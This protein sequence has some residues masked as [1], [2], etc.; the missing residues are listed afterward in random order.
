MKP[1]IEHFQDELEA[2]LDKFSSEGLTLGEV[3]GTLEIVKHNW[4]FDSREEN[5][6]ETGLGSI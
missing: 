3:I 6:D 4:I 2:V 5:E 1:L